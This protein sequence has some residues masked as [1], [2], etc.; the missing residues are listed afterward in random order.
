MGDFF[1]VIVTE[2]VRGFLAVPEEGDAGLVLPLRPESRLQG[3]CPGFVPESGTP[4]P[5]PPQATTLQLPHK[6]LC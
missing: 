5:F 3:G 6:S 1:G 4:L 2:A